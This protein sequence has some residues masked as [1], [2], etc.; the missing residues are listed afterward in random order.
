[1]IFCFCLF[2]I[3][4]FLVLSFTLSK[5]NNVRTKYST[6]STITMMSEC[7]S[8]L[9]TPGKGLDPDADNKGRTSS[10]QRLMRQK[11]LS[12]RPESR[13]GSKTTNKQIQGHRQKSKKSGKNTGCHDL[14]RNRV[15]SPNVDHTAKKSGIAPMYL[16]ALKANS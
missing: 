7:V 13:Q 14:Q 2:S 8:L 11:K 10:V 15:L 3:V 6:V 1:M 5:Y 9:N 12:Y 16:L 4:V